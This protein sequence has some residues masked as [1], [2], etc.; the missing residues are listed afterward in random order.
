[1]RRRR[2]HRRGKNHTVRNIVISCFVITLLFATG[3]SAFQTNIIINVK[4]NVKKYKVNFDPNGGY[5]DINYK[6]VGT[7]YGVLP[8]PTREG[9][10]FKGWNGKNLFN[11]YIMPIT[12][13]SKIDNCEELLLRDNAY[14]RIIENN[15]W[16]PKT[17]TTYTLIVEILENTFDTPI[18]LPTDNRFYVEMYSNNVIGVGKV[19]THLTT[20]KTR[21]DF[22]DVTIG[23]IWIWTPKSVTGVCR[24]KIGIYEGAEILEY[25]PYF[26]TE[27]TKVVQKYEHTLTAIWEENV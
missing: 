9:Y 12:G 25:E 3:Y 2:I 10:T 16:I 7:K 11:S 23:S 1:M 17:N 19:G 8:T 22:S 26:I 14:D 5:I 13:T 27:N 4:G 15:V 21:T 20:F 6:Y 18:V 24:V